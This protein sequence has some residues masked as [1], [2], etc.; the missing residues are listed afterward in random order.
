MM[1]TVKI[2]IEHAADGTYAAYGENVPAYGMGNTAD[3]A[4]EEALKGLKLYLEENKAENIPDI[5]KS[6][7]EV[8][9]QMD[10]QSLP[11]YYKG[12]LQMRLLRGLPR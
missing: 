7:Y 8:V 12:I 10:I 4:K 5:L 2:I 9:Y 11:D 3:A 1:N 6:P